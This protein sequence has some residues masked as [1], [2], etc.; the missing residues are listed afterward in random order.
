MNEIERAKY[1]IL[2]EHEDLTEILNICCNNW[3]DFRDFC[4]LILGFKN[5]AL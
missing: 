3:K 1:P 5:S 2:Y 4:T